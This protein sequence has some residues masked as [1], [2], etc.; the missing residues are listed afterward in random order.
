MGWKPL[1]NPLLQGQH[2]KQFHEIVKQGNNVIP[3]DEKLK[4]LKSIYD[5]VMSNSK[6]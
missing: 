3:S 6:L 4:Y 1:S 2:A 5:K